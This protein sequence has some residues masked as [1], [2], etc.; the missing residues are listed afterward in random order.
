VCNPRAGDRNALTGGIRKAPRTATLTVVNT[1][2]AGTALAATASG[3]YATAGVWW[4]TGGAGF[5]F[6]AADEQAA[7]NGPL[8][9]G[10]TPQQ[11]GTTM[12]I[13]GTAG[14][15]VAVAMSRRTTRV[16][17]LLIGYGAALATFLTIVLPEA[18]AV[19]Y[20]SPLGLL[21]FLRPPG[22]G[23]VHVLVLMLAG[24]AW[25]AA[26]VAYARATGGLRTASRA[27]AWLDRHRTA[28]TWAAV[29]APWGYAGVRLC[30]AAGIPFGVPHAF[31]DT[32][33]AANPGNQTVLLEL[34]LAAVAAAG[35]LLTWGLLR[36]WSRVFPRWLPVLRGRRVPPAFPVGLAGL[37]AF[38]L[39]AFG[40]SLLPGVVRFWAGDREV[41]GFEMGVL[42]PVPAVAILVWGVTLGLAALAL[43]RAATM[44]TWT[45]SPS[46][47]W[48]RTTPVRSSP[49]SAPRTPGRRLV[50]AGYRETHRTELSPTVQLVYLRKS[51]R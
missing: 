47:P 26:T 48:H 20:L 3:V 39:T 29:L 24:F 4:A 51:L 13:L 17:P 16:R 10:V 9:S 42:Y 46:R 15:V 33:N 18:R 28:V 32:I 49:S 44:D 37:V 7:D 5:P 31:L 40:V 36:P 14:T 25:A 2:R 41:D 19:K 23:T 22:W 21:A 50:G 8:L 38:D 30:W 6:G 43:R 45:T 1:G 12:A 35:S 11:A 34:F 27:G